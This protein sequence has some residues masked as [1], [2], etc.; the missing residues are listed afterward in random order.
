MGQGG[1]GASAQWPW[2]A[3]S[4][5][6]FCLQPGL[7]ASTREWGVLGQ[8][9]GLRPLQKLGSGGAPWP[10]GLT[11]GGRVPE[12][13]G[14]RPEACCAPPTPPTS[15]PQALPSTVKGRLIPTAPLA[16]PVLRPPGWLTGMQGLLP[17]SQSYPLLAGSLL[18][19]PPFPVGAVSAQPMRVVVGHGT[20]LGW[21]SAVLQCCM[22]APYRLCYS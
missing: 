22:R 14:R 2:G 12:I 17:G 1:L 15:L 21:S 4:G 13:R 20:G 8:Q 6:D 3:A 9:A 10:P 19:L 18:H 16:S 11:A 5:Q 7:D